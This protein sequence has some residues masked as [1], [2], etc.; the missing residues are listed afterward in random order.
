MRKLSANEISDELKETGNKHL[1]FFSE[2]NEIEKAKNAR[3]IWNK[4]VKRLTSGLYNRFEK[5][6]CIHFL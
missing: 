3:N 4:E 6:L 2:I 1:F 5:F